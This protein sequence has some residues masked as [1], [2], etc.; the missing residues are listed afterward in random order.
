VAS[1]RSLLRPVDP[2]G[3]PQVFTVQLGESVPSIAARLEEQ[4]FIH[5]ADAFRTFLVYAGLDTGVQAGRYQLSPAMNT[6]E[7]ARALQDA[8]PEEV[9]FIVLPGWRAEE[10]SAAL[11]TSGLSI[12][13]GEFMELVRNPPEALIPTGFPPLE[14]LEGFLLPGTYQVKRVVSAR[15]LLEVF[16]QRFD[17]SVTPDLRDGFAERGLDLAGAVTLASIVE[18]EAVVEDEQPMIAS[19]FY[20]R[21]AQ[22]MRL[23]SDPTAQYALGYQ[24][25]AGSWWKNPLTWDDLQVESRYNTYRYNGLPPGP[26]CNPGIDA[27]R[28]VANPAHTGYFFFRAKCDGTGRHAFSVTYEEHLQNACP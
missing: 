5:S 7:I 20:N 2:Q 28:A 21:L 27:L 23:E 26:I 10:I 17:E 19:V 15:S 25:S 13:P 12:D 9:T 22:G 3:E 18:R 4:G 11:P 14:S 1:E 24:F 6:V 16:L 8:V